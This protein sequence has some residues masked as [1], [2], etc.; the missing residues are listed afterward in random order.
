MLPC[1]MSQPSRIGPALSE[2]DAMVWDKRRL[3][4]KTT[5]NPATQA[6]AASQRRARA[7][8]AP[9]ASGPAVDASDAAMGVIASLIGSSWASRIASCGLVNLICLGMVE[10]GR[11]GGVA[12]RQ[13]QRVRRQLGE[14]GS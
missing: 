4:T 9:P 13:L 3:R 5:A 11:D 14:R 1:S 10:H 8:A 6:A 2:L 12:A 7:L